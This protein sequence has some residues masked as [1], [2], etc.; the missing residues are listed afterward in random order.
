MAVAYSHR[1]LFF[2]MQNKGACYV[3]QTNK[4][5][6]N[7]PLGGISLCTLDELYSADR[8]IVAK[9]IG[10]L[11]LSHA[12]NLVN[13]TLEMFAQVDDVEM[14]VTC[15]AAFECAYMD[16]AQKRAGSP[17]FEQLYALYHSARTSGLYASI[18]LMTEVYD[19]AIAIPG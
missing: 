12:Y 7:A 2:C 17:T 8:D 16:F 5:V 13:D 4:L 9:L 15:R 3:P 18:P 1:H 11:A 19:T 10:Y 6:V 14:I